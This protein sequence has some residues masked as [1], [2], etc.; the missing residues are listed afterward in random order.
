MLKKS[1]IIAGLVLIAAVVL[2]ACGSTP[3]PPPATRAPVP[4]DA[5]TVVPAPT[6]APVVVPFMDAWKASGHNNV[7]GEQFRHW[8]DATANP[9]G[10]P[11]SCAKCHTSAGFIDFAADGKV[12]NAVPAAEAQGITCA[13]CHSPVRGTSLRNSR[14]RSFPSRTATER[15]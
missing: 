5:P 13:A 9:N 6:E 10:V 12:D 2:T 3:T 8:D 7:T 4:T 14:R 15:A 11:T 1:L